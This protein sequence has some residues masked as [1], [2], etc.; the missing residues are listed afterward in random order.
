MLDTTTADATITKAR[1]LGPAWRMIAPIGAGGKSAPIA[2]EARGLATILLPN[3][4]AA[5]ETGRD[6]QVPLFLFSLMF[7]TLLGQDVTKG[8][9]KS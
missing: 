1:N 5:N 8:D 2:N 6:E 7:S 9:D 3:S 4:V